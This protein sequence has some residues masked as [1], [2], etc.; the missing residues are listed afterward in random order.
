MGLN[1]RPKPRKCEFTRH[2]VIGLDGLYT[3]S[4]DTAIHV[5]A[6]ER[7]CKTPEDILRVHTTFHEYAAKGDVR[8]LFMDDTVARIEWLNPSWLESYGHKVVLS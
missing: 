3:D 2:G 8:I 6:L 4:D 1:Q 7:H 5:Y